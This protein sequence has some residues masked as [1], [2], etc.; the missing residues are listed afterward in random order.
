MHPEKMIEE[1]LKASPYRPHDDEHEPHFHKW[2][3]RQMARVHAA[4]KDQNDNLG[5]RGAFH[6]SPTDCNKT[7]DDSN[8]PR[9]T[10]R[11]KCAVPS[12]HMY[13]FYGTNSATVQQVAV[14]TSNGKPVPPTFQEYSKAV[15]HVAR[16]GR[17]FHG[18]F[19]TAGALKKGHLWWKR[20][21]PHWAYEYK[22]LDGDAT[23]TTESATL[24]FNQF[25]GRSAGKRF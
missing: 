23:V 9:F 4:V 14:P 17:R 7:W 13:W 6:L 25:M 2:L 16:S 21:V 12:T 1:V 18:D 3:K 8:D 15:P 20:R 19:R 11:A 24:P 22:T 5:G 10:E